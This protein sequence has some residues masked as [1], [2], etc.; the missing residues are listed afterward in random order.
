MVGEGGA[1]GGLRW[2]VGGLGGG[3]GE[4]VRAGEATGRGMP[5]GKGCSGNDQFFQIGIEY[6][7]F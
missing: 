7:P 4:G 1:S 5:A 6:L 3:G 2:R